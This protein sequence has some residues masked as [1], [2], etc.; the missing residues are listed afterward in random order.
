M[1]INMNVCVNPS[2]ELMTEFNLGF[3]VTISLHTHIRI[4]ERTLN[5]SIEQV[6]KATS[7]IEINFSNKLWD[8]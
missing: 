2:T 3:A 1:H 7:A 6:F 4:F 8:V 5:L